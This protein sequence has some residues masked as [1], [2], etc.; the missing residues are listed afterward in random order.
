M[1]YYDIIYYVFG[2]IFW[3]G[4]VKIYSIVF[5]LKIII[6]KILKVREFVIMVI[7]IR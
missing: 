7:G 4:V 6:Y 1:Y 2:V 3:V 5:L